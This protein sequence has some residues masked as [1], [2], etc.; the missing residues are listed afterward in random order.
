[1]NNVNDTLSE[2][3]EMLAR[4]EERQITQTDRVDELEVNVKHI[5]KQVN[6]AHGGILVLGLL[7]VIVAFVKSIFANH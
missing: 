6:L 2:I 4:I 3:K 7:G 5:E 1:M